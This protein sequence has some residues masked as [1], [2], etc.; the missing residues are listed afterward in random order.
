MIRPSDLDGLPDNDA[1][2]RTMDQLGQLMIA[3]AAIDLEPFMRLAELVQTPEVLIHGMDPSTVASAGGWLDIATKLK[4]F[5]LHAVESVEA[6][7][8]ERKGGD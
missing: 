2:Q 3:A 4:P 6:I 5:W 1:T 8:K 7:R